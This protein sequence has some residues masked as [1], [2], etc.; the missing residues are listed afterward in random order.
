MDTIYLVGGGPSLRGFDWSRLEG[1]RV[2]AINRAFQVIPWAEIVYFSDSQFWLW[3]K[4][5]LVLHGGRKITVAKIDHPAVERYKADGPK[6]L[7]TKP[8]R[9][10]T[11]NS[12]GYAAINLAVHMGARRIVL[13]GYDMEFAKSGTHWHDGY[14][15]ATRKKSLGLMLPYFETL[16]EPLQELD[17]AV[18]NANLHSKITC[19]PR[20]DAK[21][22][23]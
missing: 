6:G 15:V 1:K 23:L 17:I 9:L 21:G 8:G 20:V 22:V 18:V 16:V 5:E 2:I 10:R 11:G 19:F 13:L 7:A 14:P 12:S 3:F 4:N